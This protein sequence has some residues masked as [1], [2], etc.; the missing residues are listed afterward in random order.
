MN[1]STFIERV[2]SHIKAHYD[3]RHDELTVVF[4]N[5]RA[6]FYLRSEFKR[7]CDNTIWLPQILSIQEA[8]EQWSGMRLAD[9]IDVLFELIDINAQLY[10]DTS[11]D[12]LL[13]G[14]QA[15]QMASDFDEIDQYDA[16]AAHVFSYVEAH[17]K[18]EI[19]NLDEHLTEKENHY[20]QFFASLIRYYTVLKERLESMGK[21]YYGMI[22]K[23][24]AHLDETTL[25]SRLKGRKILLAG[26]NALTTT[27]E[28]IIDKLVKNG[29]AT[30]LF[31]FDRY[32]V[33]DERNEAGMFARR[34]QKNHPDWLEQGIQDKLLKDEKHIR[35]INANGNTLQVKALQNTLATNPSKQCAVVLADENLLIPVLNA[36]PDS[37]PYQSLMVSM[38]YPL[39]QAALSHLITAFFGLR[40]NKKIIRK[41]ETGTPVEGWYVWPIY[42]I[43]DLEIVHILFTPYE[44]AGYNKWLNTARDSGIFL[45][46]DDELKRLQSVPAIAEFISL[47]L[48]AS[49]AALP[50][51]MLALLSRLIQFIAQKLQSLPDNNEM[52]FLLNQVS[53]TRQ[54]INRLTAIASKH[55]NFVQDL[56]SIEVLYK[57]VNRGASI[58]LSNS[59]TDGLQIMGILETRNL[60]F[61][62]LHILSVNEGTIPTDK[63]Q[64]SFIPNYIK[65]E[66]HLPGYK[67]KQA[68]F[69]Y[70]FYHLLQSSSDIYLYYNAT[71]ATSGEEAS[72]FILQMK[73]ELLPCN[74]KI[75]LEEYYFPNGKGD[76]TET[77]ALNA[78]KTPAVMEALK[79]KMGSGKGLAPTSL[80]TYIAC[81]LKFYLK[82][83]AGIEDNSMEEDLQSNVTGT[84]VHGTLERLFRDFLPQNG[85]TT[86]IDNN[87]FC[88]VIEPSWPRCFDEAVQQKLPAGLPDIGYNYLNRFIMD[89]IIKAF[90][91]YEKKETVKPIEILQ[92]EQPL[93]AALSVNGTVCNIMGYADRIDRT[94]GKIR[95]IDYKTGRVLDDDV[96]VRQ[97]APGGT[98][99]GIRDIPE[100]ALQLLLYKFMYLQMHRDIPAEDIEAAIF[101]LRYNKI[102][103]QLHVEYEPLTSAFTSAM[104]QWLNELFSEML[105]S[106]RPFTQ[107]ENDKPCRNC[108]FK[109][110]CKR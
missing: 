25:I 20:L 68:V 80:S 90:I 99:T 16:D 73:H 4:P 105:D 52:L 23:H 60:D 84:I 26:F 109:K 17:K 74:E 101:G 85:R 88:K 76:A 41:R 58:K 66:N 102:L 63:P 53:E 28:A 8:V 93:T 6:A 13:F 27:E 45:L 95:I 87:L 47:L 86:S 1:K 29:R 62:T 14:S 38:G 34:Y 46:D 77:C 5:K 51:E 83:I 22:T 91:E 98:P 72:R 65:K 61:N 3:L 9:N 55:E 42:R 97:T 81:P 49:D 2:A 110:L 106:E 15:A 18:L 78:E 32:Y 89:E 69:A 48:E 44:L 107:C 54:I 67:E 36:I 24:L 59:T 64:N 50:T 100:K 35:I 108:D 70:H 79:A 33:E 96:K 40:R 39:Q 21:G 19:W 37:D 7:Q 82:Y 43:M 56:E 31:D 104:E 71:D 10:P 12:L 92:L 57:L 103:F 75:I 30:V 11:C 94:Q